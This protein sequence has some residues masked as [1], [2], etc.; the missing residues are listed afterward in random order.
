MENKNRTQGHTQMDRE[1]QVQN[2]GH[3]KGTHKGRINTRHRQRRYGGH[4]P[5]GRWE[6]W[7]T[8]MAAGDAPDVWRGLSCRWLLWAEGKG[9]A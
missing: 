7:Q 3:L 9:V 6:S 5:R 1:G 4:V 8:E 2:R